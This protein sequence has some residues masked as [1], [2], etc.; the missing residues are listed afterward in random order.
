MYYTQLKRIGLSLLLFL[1][2][3]DTVANDLP[4]TSIVVHK[5]KHI[6]QLLHHGRVLKSFP[7]GL[8]IKSG[9]KTAQ[10]D[11]KTPEGRYRLDWRNPDSRYYRSFHISYPNRRDKV[12]AQRNRTHPGSDI[13][14]HGQPNSARERKFIQSFGQDWTAG[15]LAVSNKAMKEIWSMVKDGITIDILPD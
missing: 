5:S 13:M 14:L 9:P 8:G 2:A 4:V 7:V 12:N 11:Y 10:G 1:I 3:S 15:C 6:L